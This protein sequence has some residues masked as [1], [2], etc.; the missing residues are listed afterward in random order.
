MIAHMACEE[1]KRGNKAIGRRRYFKCLASWFTHC[2]IGCKD[3]CLQGFQLNYRNSKNNSLKKIYHPH[4]MAGERRLS[5]K[6][7]NGK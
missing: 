2:S 1:E 7:K 6:F 5:E 3:E 4:L